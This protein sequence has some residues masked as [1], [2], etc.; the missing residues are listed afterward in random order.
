MNP[1]IR[2]IGYALP[3]V[4]FP[5]SVHAQS[6]VTLYGALDTSIQ[7]AH[8]GGTS[9]T[10]LDSSNVQASEWGLT[11]AEDVGG[12]TKV[13]FKLESGF[14]VNNGAS[15]Q[16]SK[17]FGREAWVG[18][19]GP[20]G[21]VQAGLNN[22][23]EMWGLIRFSAG[24]LGHWVWGQASN[25]YDFFVS[26]RIANS[27]IYT[28]PN[29]LGFTFSGMYARGA[30]GDATL[31]RTLGDTFSVGVNYARG[32][33]SFEAD[34]LSQVY[35]TATPITASSSTHAGNHDLFG[36]SYDFGFAKF[37][38]LLV[39][40]RGAGNVTAVNSTGYA[41]PNNLYYDISAQIPNVLNGTLMF[42]FG[43]YKL[44]A[45]SAGNSTS[46]G[47]RYDY[48]LSPRTGLYVGVAAVR[49]GSQ[50]SFNVN[51]AAYSGITVAAGKNDLAGIVGMIHRF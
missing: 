27:I 9:T 3:L 49:N 13:I 6:S 22:S 11:G 31:P 51:G 35:T 20:Y 47:A 18:M 12:G 33:L 29:V 45:N 41:D 16:T 26:T 8:S 38:G 39:L 43:Q 19:S 42:S 1:Y 36:V 7:Y 10:R 34:Y 4:A 25:N 40:H 50:A 24:D 28:S 15:A 17:I 30:N 37:D 44:Q 23:P 32:P 14:N 46:Y 21:R 2:G 48:R 5:F